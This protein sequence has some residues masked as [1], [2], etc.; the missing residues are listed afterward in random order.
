MRLGAPLTIDSKDPVA[1]AQ[2][3]VDLGYRAGF[4]PWSLTMGDLPYLHALRDAFAARDVAIA[5]VIGWRN[6]LPADEGKRNKGT[7]PRGASDQYRS[8]S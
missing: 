4:C 7:C 3:H 8:L 2:A 1:L 6:L 5:E